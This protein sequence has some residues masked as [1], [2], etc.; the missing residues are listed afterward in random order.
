M[1]A[2]SEMIAPTRSYFKPQFQ[3]FP[4]QTVEEEV[5]ISQDK[6]MKNKSVDRRVHK[7][8]ILTETEL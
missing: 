8:P 1:F 4:F 7:A 2:N 6:S 5:A 3:K